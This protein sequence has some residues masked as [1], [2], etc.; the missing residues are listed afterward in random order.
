MTEILVTKFQL[1][2]IPMKEISFVE[3]KSPLIIGMVSKIFIYPVWREAQVL[4]EELALIKVESV[5]KE[6]ISIIDLNHYVIITVI[7]SIEK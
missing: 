1:T 6:K 5:S 4:L 2:K 3:I 7:N